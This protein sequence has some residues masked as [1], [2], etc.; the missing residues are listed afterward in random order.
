MA[1]NE[2]HMQYKKENG[3]SA[4][5]EACVLKDFIEE[6]YYTEVATPEY[7]EWLENKLQE[8]LSV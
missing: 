7:I 6:N 4:T 8:L 5:M 3:I 1:F 2:L